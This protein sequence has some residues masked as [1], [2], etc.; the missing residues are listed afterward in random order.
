MV[1]LLLVGATLVGPFEDD[2]F[3]AVLGERLGLAVGVGA[4]EVGGQGAGRDGEGG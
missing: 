1:E 2:E 3:A 4:L